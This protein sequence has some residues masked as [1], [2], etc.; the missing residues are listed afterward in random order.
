MEAGAPPPPEPLVKTPQE[1]AASADPA[2]KLEGVHAWVAQLDRK[3]QTRFYALAAAAVLALAAGIVAVVLALGVQDDSAT[4]SE[5]QELRDQ[6][7]N[8]TK[9]A[10]DAAQDDV[11]DLDD[12]LAEIESQIESL[13]SDQST[14]NKELSVVQ[15][16]IADLRD[17]IDSVEQAQ[18]DAAAANDTNTDDTTD[19]GSP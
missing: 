16:D 17:Q 13:S 19:D 14:T 8:A 18:E 4:K 1:A 11:A 12:R 9:S 10:S 3:L 6:V 15:D 7:D 2:E 5:L